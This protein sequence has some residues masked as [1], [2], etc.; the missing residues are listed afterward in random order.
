V[1]TEAGVTMHPDPCLARDLLTAAVV[2]TV[3]AV[4][5]LLAFI[6]GGGNRDTEG[7]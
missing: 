3:A 5:F 7:D 6:A 1:A 2:V 4:L